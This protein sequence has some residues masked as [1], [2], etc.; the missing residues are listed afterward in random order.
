MRHNAP[1]LYT[2][3]A[4][5]SAESGLR[6]CLRPPL[7]WVCCPDFPLIPSSMGNSPLLVFNDLQVINNKQEGCGNFY[8]Q[9]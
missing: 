8:S 9:K 2:L 3:C 5:S 7:S 4:V 6:G 1:P